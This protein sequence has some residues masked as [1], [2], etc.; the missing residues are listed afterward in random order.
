METSGFL[1]TS[2]P[3]KGWRRRETKK[4][5]RAD[6]EQKMNE[7]AAGRAGRYNDTI[8][9]VADYYMTCRVPVVDHQQQLNQIIYL[10]A[11]LL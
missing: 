1:E 6:G 3:A 8:N 7:A 10:S 11:R 9:S 5:W 4:G 2:P